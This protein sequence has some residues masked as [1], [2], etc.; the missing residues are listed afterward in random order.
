MLTKKVLLIL[1]MALRTPCQLSDSLSD[2]DVGIHKPVIVILRILIDDATHHAE[3]MGGHVCD[4]PLVIPHE[5]D[6]SPD[7]RRA[8]SGEQ[9]FL[10]PDE[11]AGV[12]FGENVGVG[13]E[14]D[15]VVHW[16][17]GA[18][19][20]GNLSVWSKPSGGCISLYCS[21]VQRL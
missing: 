5:I 12:D 18:L 20:D 21:I 19:V 6:V 2:G 13:G 10:V 15:I 16:L 4:Y 8:M 7:S 3:T 9:I 17:V 11:K 14:R 1:Y